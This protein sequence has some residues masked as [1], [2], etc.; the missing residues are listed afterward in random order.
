MGFLTRAKSGV[1]TATAVAFV[2][3]LLTMFVAAPVYADLYID[4]TSVTIGNGIQQINGSYLN[5]QHLADNLV[6]TSITIQASSDITIAD[7]IDMSTSALGT[8]QFNLTLI[9]PTCNVDNNFNFDLSGHL[10]LTCNT[11]NLN[12]KI[13]S[14]GSS[15][16]PSRVTGT[17]T[18]VNVLSNSASIQQGIDLSS[19]TSPVTV[20]VG[21]DQYTENL[22]INKQL[23]VVGHEGNPVGAAPDAP[24]INGVQPGGNVITVTGNGVKI[25]GLYL[26]G[27]VNGGSSTASVDGIF[28]N[29]VDS[30]SAYKNN[31]YQFSGPG[32]DTT[33]STNSFVT[34][35]VFNSPP[36]QIT[37]AVSGYQDYGS[38]SPQFYYAGVPFGLSFT[39]NLSCTTVDGGTPINASLSAG[40]H[41]IDASSCSGFNITDGAHTALY[42]SAANNFI[43]GQ[44]SQTVGFTTSSPAHAVVN[45]QSYSP[46]ASATSGLA[47]SIT[48]DASAASVCTISGGDVSF[49]NAGTCVLDANQAG[50]SNYNA[51]SQVQ[52]AFTVYPADQ[53]VS[54]TS[55]A[56]AHA[57]IGGAAYS[58]TAVATSGL[59]AS[60]TVDASSS[61]VCTISG[62]T[63]SFLGAGTCTLD[64][65]Q[66][67][68]ASYSAAPQVQ[69]S[70]TVNSAL[71]TWSGFQQPV[72]ADGSSIF[73]LGRTVPVKFQLTGASAGITNLQAALYVTKV[74]NSIDGT[75]VEAIST[76]AADS[77]NTFRYDPSNQQYVFNLGTSSL[78]AGTY[79]LKIYV[80]GDNTTG[81]LLGSVQVSVK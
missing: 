43:V 18:Q 38:A 76:S 5:A 28:A 78:T 80:N 21:A 73:K 2:A 70:F 52:Q 57:V 64:A 54:F 72:N 34:Q 79:K 75:D 26:N 8:P 25:V 48:I 58:P 77:G 49:Q 61:S 31:V 46:T 69:Q 68:N 23:T 12:G 65:N 67:G 17:A 51:A 71:P 11:L 63:V 13:T 33:G 60:V 62:G 74:T 14:G 10:N 30:L 22:T 9:A 37:V 36:N 32:I 40:S 4:P 47:A 66:S 7:N 6:V 41:T 29:N 56:P 35:N 59:T 45:G 39:D 81:T 19:T 1:R 16:D 27:L 53:T 44:S 50:D 24:T 15:I 55:T 42:T 20:Q 3:S